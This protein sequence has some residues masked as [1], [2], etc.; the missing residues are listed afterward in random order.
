MTSAHSDL[1]DH[2]D[3]RQCECLNASKEHTLRHAMELATRE[4]TGCF[5]QSD[6]DEELLIHITMMQ[7]CKISAI[8]IEGPADAAPSS[9]LLFVNRIGLDFDSAKGEAPTQTIPLSP[10][11]VSSSAPP[12]ELR[13]VLFQHV[14]T[15]SIFVP[16]NLG[17][18]EETVSAIA[19]ALRFGLH[20]LFCLCLEMHRRA[21]P[22]SRLR[23]QI[24]SKLVLI[25][26]PIQHSGLK[27]T[28]E[29]QKAATTGDW[30]N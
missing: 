13:Y 4:D 9:V 16:G 30:L 17:D 29:Q 5:L 6:C 24:I 25:G 20:K 3:L 28:E 21:F 8:K 7:G 14:Q 15:L 18:T 23:P 22:S 12:V 27:R 10:A 19:T 26:E 1:L 2:I 11:A